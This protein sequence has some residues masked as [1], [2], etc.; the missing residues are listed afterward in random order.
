MNRVLIVK[1]NIPKDKVF[2]L[3]IALIIGLFAIIVVLNTKHFSII[4]SEKI[5]LKK[6]L[7]DMNLT[8]NI[9]YTE[10]IYS[11]DIYI[12]YDYSEDVDRSCNKYKCFLFVEYYIN[13]E[14]SYSAVGPIIN[15]SLSKNTGTGTTIIPSIIMETIE[16]PIDSLR[17]RLEV[18]YG[19]QN[20]TVYSDTYKLTR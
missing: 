4:D 1:Q 2:L 3:L 16:N 19:D 12:D 15:L 8:M 7:K 9:N 10:Q 11:D 20:V 18:F 17:L 6:E 5:D 14:N 13:S